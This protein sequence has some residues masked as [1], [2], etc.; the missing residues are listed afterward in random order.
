MN[1]EK[2]GINYWYRM[3]D[4]GISYQTVRNKPIGQLDRGI[5]WKR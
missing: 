1:T 4:N 2:T 5:P 3:A